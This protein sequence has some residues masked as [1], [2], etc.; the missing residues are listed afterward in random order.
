MRKRLIILSVSLSIVAGALIAYAVSSFKQSHELGSGQAAFADPSV[1]RATDAHFVTNP[2]TSGS[3]PDFTTAAESGVK[4]VVNIE[5]RETVRAR[6]YGNYQNQG[7]F[8]PFEFFFGPQQPQRRP[9]Q[10][11]QQQSESSPEMRTVAGGSGVIISTDGYIISNNHVVENAEEIVVTLHDGSTYKAKI[12]GTDPATDIALIKIEAN[13]LTAMPFGNSDDLRLGEWVL[14]IGNPYGLTSTVTAGIVS[15]KGRSLGVIGNN[16][17]G[18]ES[19]IQTDAAVNPGNS[20]G[21]LVTIDGNLVGINT[22]IKS[23]T[24]TYAGYSFA[25]P[26]TIV[27]KVVTDLREHGVVQRAMLGI[28]FSAITSDWIERFGKEYGITERGGVFVGDVV[29]GGA[30]EAA[31][32]KKGDV[33]THIGGQPMNSTSDVQETIARLRPNDKIN[34]TIKRGGSVKQIEVTLRNRAGKTEL[35][36]KEDVDLVSLLGA[37]F[38]EIGEKQKKDLR[39]NGGIQ[40]VNL[41]ATGLLAQSRVQRGFIITAINDQPIHSVSDLARITDKVQSI[42]GVYPD[43]RIVSYQAMASK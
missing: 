38:R 35:V 1:Q 5:R 28:A 39:I 2:S 22:V 9:Q 41:S 23:P 27:R 24:G 12:I 6:Q 7:S 8:D 29:E 34:V 21:A 26:S 10:P 40:V 15:A 37:E 43:G 30:A 4:S 3:Y 17:L 25:V 36:S 16:Q 32:I 33:L 13:G 20:G 19:F 11:E 42:D 31:G 18:I 14:A